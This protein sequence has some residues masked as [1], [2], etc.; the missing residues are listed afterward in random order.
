VVAPHFGQNFAPSAKAVPQ[1]LQNAIDHLVDKFSSWRSI[2]YA[3]EKWAKKEQMAK[4]RM[5]KE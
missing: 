3:S 5:A 4:E 1:E 2:S